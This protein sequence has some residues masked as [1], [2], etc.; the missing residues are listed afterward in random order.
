MKII[1]LKNIALSRR[2]RILARSQKLYPEVQFQVGKILERVRKRGDSV[3]FEY[4]K[5]FEGVTL[6]S[7]KV[8]PSEIKQAHAKLD[9]ETQQALKQSIQ[10]VT[11]VHLKQ[12]PKTISTYPRPGIKITRV[13]KP[14]EKIGVYIPGGKASYPSSV[15]MNL[16]PAKIAGCQEIIVCTPPQVDGSI[17]PAV[18]VSCDLLGVSQIFKVGGA[19]AIA[20]LGFGTKSIPRVNKIFGAGGIYVTSAK[21]AL[22]GKVNIDMPAGPSEVFIIADKEANPKF[23][24]ADLLADCEHGSDS[25][26]IVLTTSKSL[27]L[28]VISQIDIQLKSLSTKS[29]IK[30]SLKNFGLVALVENLDEAIE[31]ANE[32][33]PEHLELMTSSNPGLVSKVKNAGS[34]LIGPYTA[35]AAADYG[36]GSNHVLPTGQSAKSFSGLTVES[37]GKFIEFQ[38]VSKKGL[39]EIRQTIETIAETESLPAH[40]NS[41]TM[42]FINE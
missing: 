38:Q 35:K 20:A 14:I 23:V 32:Y 27:A 37:F 15:I 40:K 11:R 18:L 3:L 39:A 4:A 28:E 16:V 34:V 2:R 26:G 7:L 17:S 21:L 33:A 25:A 10:N 8:S 9:L 36:T 19:Q 41:S 24:A 31:F 13:F 5:E 30:A 22:F 12:L 42:R 6:S 1:N 29:R